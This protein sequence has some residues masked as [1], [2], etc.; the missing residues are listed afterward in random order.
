MSDDLLSQTCV[1]CQGGI[2]PL[3]HDEAQ[4]FLAQVPE[5]ALVDE[6]HRLERSFSFRNFRE[7][8][9]FVVAVGEL[10]EA[11]KHHPDIR[12]GWG[13]ATISWKTKKIKGLHENDFIM[14]AKTDRLFQA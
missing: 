10:A 6:G 4:G 3:T 2:A 14:A 9:D 1:P 8:L 12:F 5:W 11:Q 13:T 7:A